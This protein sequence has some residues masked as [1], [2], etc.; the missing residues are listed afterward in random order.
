[1][2]LSFLGVVPSLFSDANVEWLFSRY[3][4]R[5]RKLAPDGVHSPRLVLPL[6]AG[7][8]RAVEIVVV[9]DF[10]QGGGGLLL[11]ALAPP[12]FICMIF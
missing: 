12:L 6:G 10:G 7:H 2:P 1:L 8:V 11:P 5:V 9:G 3:T 4:R